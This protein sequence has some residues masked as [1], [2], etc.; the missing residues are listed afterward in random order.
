MAVESRVTTLA[1]GCEIEG[2]TIT[3]HFLESIEENRVWATN[4]DC[5]EKTNECRILYVTIN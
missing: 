3:L 2:E 5:L 4:K 1:C